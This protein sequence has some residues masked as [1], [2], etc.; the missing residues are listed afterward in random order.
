MTNFLADPGFAQTDAP[1]CAPA[2]AVHSR[3]KA[4][5]HDKFYTPNDVAA[6]C[7][8]RLM[9]VIGMRPDDLYIEP[10][11]GAGAFCAHLPAERLIALDVAPEAPGI[12]TQD[13]LRF[14]FPEHDARLILIGNP[15]FGH[16]GA[17]ARQFLRKAMERADIV[18]FILPGSYAKRSMQRGINRFFHLAFEEVLADQ[19]FETP[20]GEHKVRTVYQIWVRRAEARDLRPEQMPEADFIFVR[21]ISDANLVIRRVGARAGA[22]FGVPDVAANPAS[23][24]GYSRNSNYFIR[25]EGCDPVVLMIRLQGLDLSALAQDG[26][27]PSLSKPDILAAYNDAWAGRGLVSTIQERCLDPDAKDVAKRHTYG[28]KAA[29]H[30]TDRPDLPA[31]NCSAVASTPAIRDVAFEISH[32]GKACHPH[33]HRPLIDAPPAERSAHDGMRAQVEMSQRSSAPLRSLSLVSQPEPPGISTPPQSRCASPA[34]REI[35]PPIRASGRTLPTSLADRGSGPQTSTGH[36][37]LQRLWAEDGACA[38]RAARGPPAPGR[39]TGGWGVKPARAFSR[40]GLAACSWVST[41][42]RKP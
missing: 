11:A 10:S 12:E 7:V 19:A 14:Q 20:A 23:P 8:S 40:S 16:N 5:L 32:S 29:S 22:V 30:G 38:G 39:R 17:L 35:V 1:L 27:M 31:T 28:Q 21:D 3:A 18:A 13:F 2:P 6:R 42:Q 41:A 37:P 24:K 33:D 9:G 34:Q 4:V 26:I 15:P 36:T 25:A